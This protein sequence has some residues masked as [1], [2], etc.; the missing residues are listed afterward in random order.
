MIPGV[1]S[2]AV[3]L[4]LNRTGAIS[5]RVI[6]AN[7][8]PV[9]GAGI[10]LEP[11]RLKR[12]QSS[13]VSYATTDDN[14]N[15]RA[16]HIAPGKYRV[17]ASYSPG[18][19]HPDV[20][21]QIEKDGANDASAEVYGKT[22]YPGTLDVLQATVIQIDPGADLHGIDIGL[23]HTRSVRISGH[24]SSATGPL[25]MLVMLSAIGGGNSIDSR[26]REDGSF[27]LTQVPPGRYILT[28]VTG[29]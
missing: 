18:R 19:E 21:M 13:A 24:V 4:E 27:E 14:G 2:D 10:Q 12:S 9:T 15:Y 29:H 23:L 26:V 1:L 11:M 28:S 20:K 8:E 17:F 22:Y 7:G 5:G 25:I 3:T 16:Y 6:D